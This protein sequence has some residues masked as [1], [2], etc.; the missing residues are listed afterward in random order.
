MEIIKLDN[1]SYY[2]NS[3]NR[4]IITNVNLVVNEGDFVTIKGPS[5][6]GKTTLLHIC[7]SLLFP[8]SG[9]AKIFG[10]ESLNSTALL[11]RSKIGFVFQTSILL[12]HVTV[13]ENFSILAQWAGIDKSRAENDGLELLDKFNLIDYSNQ[14]PS[15]MSLGQRQR[16]ALIIPM[17]LRPRLILMD[18][19]LG[20]IDFE[21][22][23]L[24][25]DQIK[26]MKEEGTT[27]V[28]VT[29][30]LSMDKMSDA[31][32]YLVDGSLK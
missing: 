30:D 3:L 5:G 24:V 29:H 21:L 26:L 6:S 23:K 27:M 18:E 14:F 28:I 15:K 11:I 9:M 16:V 2:L 31:I 13:R 19:P 25:I 4:F 17:L 1:I 12:E 8:T 10:L 22:K 20:S 32:Y 7:G